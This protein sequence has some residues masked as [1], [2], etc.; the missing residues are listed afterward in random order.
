[1][2]LFCISSTHCWTS[3]YEWTCEADPTGVSGPVLYVKRPGYY[4]C[5]VTLQSPSATCTSHQIEVVE[6]LVDIIAVK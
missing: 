3:E 5:I 2:T 4:Q 6:G 1:M